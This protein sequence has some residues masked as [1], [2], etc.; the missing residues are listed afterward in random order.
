MDDAIRP[1]PDHFAPE[2]SVETDIN[3]KPMVVC[4]VRRKATEADSGGLNVNLS[5][6]F[7]LSEDAPQNGRSMRALWQAM[8]Q[9]L[10]LA[11]LGHVDELDALVGTK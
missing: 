9:A 4:Y 1:M 3:G 2:L 7:L 6:G 11:R 10:E 8:W 5:F